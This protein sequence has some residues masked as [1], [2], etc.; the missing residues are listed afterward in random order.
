MTHLARTAACLLLVL[1]PAALQAQDQVFDLVIR[2]GRVIDGTGSPWYAGDVAVRDG[3]IAAIGMLEGAA[4]RRT[5]YC[6][7]HRRSVHSTCSCATNGS[8]TS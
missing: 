7:L 1:A 8:R 3:H 2:N 6:P 5:T 4:T